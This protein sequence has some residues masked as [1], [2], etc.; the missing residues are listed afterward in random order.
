MASGYPY[1]ERLNKPHPPNQLEISLEPVKN[2]SLKAPMV[3]ENLSSSLI[4]DLAAIVLRR[5]VNT[6][7]VLKHAYVR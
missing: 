4:A 6:I 5:H 2:R 3:N 1:N 7:S